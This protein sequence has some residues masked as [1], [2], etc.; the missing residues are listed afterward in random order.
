MESLMLHRHLLSL[1]AWLQVMVLILLVSGCETSRGVS[2]SVKAAQAIDPLTK[3]RYTLALND[4][5]K[6]ITNPATLESREFMTIVERGLANR[7]FV[8]V[9]SIAEAE[10]CVVAGYLV[11]EPWFDTQVNNFGGTTYISQSADY[12]KMLKINAFDARTSVPGGSFT[13][14][15]NV[16]AYTAGTISLGEA[17]PYLTHAAL[18]QLG[19]PTNR[20]DVEIRYELDAPEV[21]QLTA[22]P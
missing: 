9:L 7:G 15:W 2:V 17:F 12:I 18:R 22:A 21:K 5:G 1:F 20:R 3:N 14:L 19:R 8:R 6:I 10:V 11:G 4:D 16:S 13:E